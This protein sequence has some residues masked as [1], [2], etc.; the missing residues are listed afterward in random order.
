MKK[1]T[2]PVILHSQKDVTKPTPSKEFTKGSIPDVDYDWLH[3]APKFMWTIHTMIENDEAM[4]C[5]RFIY[6]VFDN[7]ISGEEMKRKIEKL[8]RYKGIE[9]E[10]IDRDRVLELLEEKV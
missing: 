3:D 5:E 2:I 6:D 7:F 4:E 1:Q 9:K 8:P 10:W